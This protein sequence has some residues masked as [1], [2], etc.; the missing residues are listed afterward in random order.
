MLKKQNQTNK[1]KLINAFFIF[2]ALGFISNL[3]LI[4]EQDD[5][6]WLDT[7]IRSLA[8]N[9]EAMNR[10]KISGFVQAQYM[11]A[12][13]DGMV[14]SL[15]GTFPAE[16]HNLFLIRRGRLKINYTAGIANYVIQFNGTES[17]F[18]LLD[19]FAEVKEPWLNMFSLRAGVFKPNMDQE[20]LYGSDL[21]YCNEAATIIQKFF[22]TE[23][24]MGAQV[25]IKHPEFPLSLT[26]AMLNGATIASENDN[27]KNFTAR[28]LYDDKFF[29]GKFRVLLAAATYQGGVYQATPNVFTMNGNIF[30]L[31]NDIANVGQQGERN[32]YVGETTIE[33]KSPAGKTWLNAEYWFG[34][35]TASIGSINSP[36]SARPTGD[37]YIRPFQSIFGLLA[38]EIQGTNTAIAT[39]FD[40]FDPNTSVSGNEIGATNSHT[41]A[42]D[43]RYINLSYGLIFTPT[44][45]L[46]FSLWY[47][48]PINETTQHIPAYNEKRKNNLLTFTMQAR[49]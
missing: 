5:I 2:V 25:M 17:K 24:D 37:S 29:D 22:P 18:Q 3:N 4:A 26:A 48:M 7:T 20:L 43:I 31:N 44:R 23:Y 49:F 41:G 16:T 6:G 34:K 40:Y 21:R 32:Y 12:A 28:L 46:R 47:D 39:K 9:V 38:H 11:S 13:S 19:A 15:S 14:S 8:T 33:V 45:H 30:T 27:R 1:T 35:Q 42:A 36:A 10:L